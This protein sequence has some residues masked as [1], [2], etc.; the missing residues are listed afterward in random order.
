M[1]ALCGDAALLRRPALPPRGPQMFQIN[2]SQGADGSRTSEQE[3]SDATSGWDMVPFLD[4]D[5]NEV[6]LV[7]PPEPEN[8]FVERKTRAV[9][10]LGPPGV[11]T[12]LPQPHS[13][14][15]FLPS[16]GASRTPP[17]Q[18]AFPTRAQVSLMMIDYNQR[19]ANA[20]QM[21][22][23]GGGKL[24]SMLNSKQTFD[25]M[26]H[27]ISKAKEKVLVTMFTFDRKELVVSLMDA[28]GRGVKVEVIADMR[29][30]VAGN[31]RDQ[32]SNVKILI[33]EGIDV[34]LCEGTLI[35]G[36]YAQVGRFV[37]KE[38][39]G[40]QH[41]KTVLSDDHLLL[42]SCNMTTSSEANQELNVL[43]ELEAQGQKR[44]EEWFAE[45]KRQSQGPVSSDPKSFHSFENYVGHFAKDIQSRTKSVED[46]KYS[47][48][49]ASQAG[50][51][52]QAS[53]AASADR[54]SLDRSRQSD[55]SM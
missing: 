49:R 38:K 16:Q 40:V 27:I 29:Q 54:I 23:H 33:M 35:E 37:S 39:K 36:P 46:R 30:T 55:S 9:R 18:P 26:G 5:G 45:M 7:E 32:C 51:R 11:P 21:M 2:T 31:C 44:H 4:A 13:S 6:G 47:I 50:K 28:V 10:G 19:K 52:S 8:T 42:G 22:E 53:R 34:Y 3:A 25:V 41:S 24:L 12:L 14:H 43:L 20:A 1:E 15:G 48:A 17:E